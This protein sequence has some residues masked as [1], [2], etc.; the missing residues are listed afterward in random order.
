[1]KK[2]LILFLALVGA[3]NLQLSSALAQG[4]AFTYQ[5]RLNAGGNPANGLYDLQFTLFNA[6]ANGAQVAAR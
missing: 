2:K 6:A 4:T 1:M 5:G 3:I